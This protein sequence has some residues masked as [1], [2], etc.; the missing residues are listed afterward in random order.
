MK[1][2]AKTVLATA[3]ILVLRSQAWTAEV[4]MSGLVFTHY[5]YVLSN[6]LADGTTAQS[7]NSFDVGRVYLNA[8]AKFTP[9]IKGFVQYEVNLL[10]RDATANS[11]YLKQGLLEISDIY[12]DAKI[13]LGLIPSSWR[14]YE[15]G[16]WKHRFVS[17]ILDDIEGFFGATDRG[18]RLSGKIP[19]VA[20][21]LAIINGEA[22]KANETKASKYKD[23]TAKV[24]ISP[25]KEGPL[26]GLKINAYLHDGAYDQDL[27]RDRVLAG[28]SYESKKFNLMG[29]S[30][31][32][33]SRATPAS[34]EAKGE[35]FSVH[36]VYNL[37]DQAWV[38]AR[39]DQWDPDKNVNDDARSR[40]FGGVG[41]KIADGVRIT[42]D[43]QGLTREKETAT[44]KDENVLF[45]HFELKF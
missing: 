38:F 5:E 20:Y 35:G 39:F 12:P 9:K 1:K 18:V 26:E 15:E 3:A 30:Y 4:K 33:K 31:N 28:L 40:V 23:Y 13:M 16:I 29:T 37:T 21:D 19:H 25:F 2:S 24:A 11:V 44:S 14:G 42:V 43:Y 8:E 7:Q 45:T 32:A 17:K 10:T 34:A 6:Y 41:Y 27:P 36:G 22:T